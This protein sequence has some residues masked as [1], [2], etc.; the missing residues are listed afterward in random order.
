MVSAP[1]RTF[2]RLIAEDRLKIG[3][4]EFAVM[5]GAGHSPEQVMLYSEADNLILCGDQV[6]A[7]ISPNVSVEAKDP[8]AICSASYLRSLASLK[9]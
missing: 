3:G 7:K 6:L 8:K 1:P 5:T 9:Q 2:L 4:R